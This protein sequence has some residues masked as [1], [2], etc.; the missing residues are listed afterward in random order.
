MPYVIRHAFQNAFVANPGS[1]GSYTR[2]LQEAQTF[3]TKEEAN[4]NCCADNEYVVSVE[5]AMK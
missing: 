3:S 2:F 1:K 5:D 4:K